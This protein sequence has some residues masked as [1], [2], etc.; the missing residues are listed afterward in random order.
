MAPVYSYEWSGEMGGIANIPNAPE[1]TTDYGSVGIKVVG[2]VVMGS[3][4]PVGA[5]FEMIEITD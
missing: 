2:V 3:D 5:G 1:V 4:G